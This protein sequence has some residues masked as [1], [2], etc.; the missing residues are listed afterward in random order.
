MKRITTLS[1]GLVLA[2]CS[3]V[4]ESGE[5][6]T[7]ELSLEVDIVANGNGTSVVWGSLRDP[8]GW[9]IELS[10]EDQL[11]AEAKDDERDLRERGL[12]EYT[13]EF[14]IDDVGT[15]FRVALVRGEESDAKGTAVHLPAPFQ[16]TSPAAGER[17]YLGEDT[18]AITWDRTARDEMWLHVEGSCIDGISTQLA[19]DAGRYLVHPGELTVY[20]DGCI[21]EI[22]VERIRHGEIDGGLGGGYI[23]AKQVRLVEVELR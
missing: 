3:Y 1:I 14:P 4:E 10:G 9:E 2:A 11:I 12:G 21:A 15:E 17:F 22:R 5:Y 16:L 19:T 23:Q 18:I 6:R 20:G 8:S 7:G 13:A